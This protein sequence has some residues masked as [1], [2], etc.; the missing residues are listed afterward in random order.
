MPSDSTNGR[1]ICA[2]SGKNTRKFYQ[3]KY[4]IHRKAPPVTVVGLRPQETPK[5]A[6][7][8]NYAED[9]GV[10]NASANHN[11]SDENNDAEDYDTREKW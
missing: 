1:N 4:G 8:F 10:G 9:I 3:S 6:P 11:N 2:T 5:I 7:A